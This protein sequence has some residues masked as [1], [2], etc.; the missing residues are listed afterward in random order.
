MYIYIQAISQTNNTDN[1]TAILPD[2]N[3]QM[4][5]YWHFPI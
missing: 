2:V 1:Q 3:L 5:T 4:K